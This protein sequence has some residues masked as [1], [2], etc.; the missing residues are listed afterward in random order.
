MYIYLLSVSRSTFLVR[1]ISLATYRYGRSPCRRGILVCHHPWGLRHQLWPRGAQF[2]VELRSSFLEK[3]IGSR[4]GKF[5]SQFQMDCNLY[6]TSFQNGVRN[7]VYPAHIQSLWLISAIAL[8]LHFAGY[9]APFNLTNRILVHLP[10]NTINWQVTACFLAALVVWL[11]IC[12]TMRYTLKLLL[13]YKGWMYESRAPGSR[14]SLPTMLW[15][16][17]VRVLSSWN[18]P[19]LYSFQG[20]LPRLPLPS[21]KDTM[22]RYL[23][24][25][26]PL[27]D[28]ENYTRME[29]LAKEF[30]QTI[31][32]KLQWYLILKSW[33]STNYVSDWWEEYVY[34]RGRSPLCVN[35]NF[36]GTDAIFM[37]LTDKQAARAANVISLLLNFR[38]L[39]EHQEL[40]PVS[41]SI[42]KNICVDT[43]LCVLTPTLDLAKYL[44]YFTAQLTT[45]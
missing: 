32:K 34:L 21:V 3:A 16:A 41:N 29:R 20:S 12:F 5:K 40:Q 30:E 26:R 6:V 44:K 19:G 35:S 17:V 24:S 14:V 31:G 15:V 1:G 27:L 4:K 36:Y 37:N 22:T 2:G 25:V 7:G 38:R 42:F 9:Q 18:K 33:W 23:R 39:I 10:S 28:D 8:G 13:M 45:S 11:S 43:V